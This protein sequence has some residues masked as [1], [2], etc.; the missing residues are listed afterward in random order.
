M[1]LGRFHPAALGGAVPRLRLALAG[2][3]ALITCALAVGLLGFFW[4]NKSYDTLVDQSVPTLVQ[5]ELLGRRMTELSAMIAQLDKGQSSE[6]LAE[7]RGEIERRILE[8]V[9]ISRS[10]LWDE[11]SK[12]KRDIIVTELQNIFENALAVSESRQQIIEIENNFQIIS[13]TLLDN[14]TQ[15]ERYIEPLVYAAT[16]IFGNSID[17]LDKSSGGFEEDQKESLISEVF[18]LNGLAQ[19]SFQVNGTIDLIEQIALSRSFARSQPNH[20][21]VSFNIRGITQ[22]LSSIKNRGDRAALARQIKELQRLFFGDGGVLSLLASRDA[23]QARMER[24]KQA[25]SRH[26]LRVSQLS[27]T[28]VER[29]RGQIDM[30]AKELDRVWYRTLVSVGVIS[31]IVFALIGVV[32]LFVVERQISGRMRRL[33]VAVREISEG[34][35]DHVVILPGRDELAEMAAALEVFRKNALELGRSNRE[36]A[37]FAYVAAHDLRSPLRGIKSLAEWTIEDAGEVLPEEAR[38]NLSMIMDRIDRLSRLLTDLLDYSK[39]GQVEEHLQPIN[40]GK[41]VGEMAEILDQ[42]GKF[43]IIYSGPVDDVVTFAT[44]FKANFVEFAEQRNQAP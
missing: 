14:R 44:P 18:S 29:A 37:N 17:K 41:V 30:S 22:N 6:E 31:A 11:G 28:L 24:G 33:T 12:E 19:L 27:D 3:V 20:G 9:G 1:S 42:D 5:T 21:R 43:R 35:T 36:L 38:E 7:Q 40:V 39:V 23:E 8:L 10:S 4:A 2:I 15:F 34:N 16:D 32:A 26:V 13:D 25:Q